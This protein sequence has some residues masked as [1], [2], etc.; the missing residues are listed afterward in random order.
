MSIGASSVRP[1]SQTASVRPRSKYL[2][3]SS[4][5]RRTSLHADDLH[6]VLAWADERAGAPGASGTPPPSGLDMERQ[7]ERRR[8][9]A[10]ELY[11][12]EKR[13]V[14]GL[15]ALDTLYYTPLLRALDRDAI[16][17]R[18][19]LNRL[20]A[21]F[22]DILQLSR[23]LLCRLEERVGDP[24]ALVAAAA[25]PAAPA[26]AAPEWDPWCDL[27]G[28]LL[29]PIAPFFKMYT[30]FMQNFAGAMQCLADERATNERFAAFLQRAEAD[31]AA[32]GGGAELGLQAQLLTLVQ[33]VPRYRLL[34]QQLLHHTPTW[35]ADHAPLRRTY[36][37]VDATAAAIN[38][39]VRQ[40]EL[41]LVALSL[42][43][44]LVG[45]DEPLVVPGRRLLRHG[46]LLKTRRKDIQP[47]HVYLFSDCLLVTSAAHVRA[48]RGADDETPWSLMAGGASLYL[49]HKLPL[50]ACTVVAYDEPVPMCAGLPQSRSM[51]DL[52]TGAGGAAVPLRHRF[53]VHSPQC[54]FSLYAASA[55]AKH[56]WITAIREAHAD[57]L[58]AMR[59]LRKTRD[60]AT[61]PRRA[62]SSSS[63]SSSG[64]SQLSELDAAPATPRA[65]SRPRTPVSDGAT[66]RA[67]PVLA[68]YHP[69]VWVPDSVA[70]Q[71]TRCAEPFTLWRRRHH[72]RLCGHVFCAT[73]SAGAV[74]VPSAAPGGRGARARACVAC[75]AYACRAA[76]ALEPPAAPDERD[77]APPTTPRVSTAT[78]PA[79]RL[80]L[81]PAPPD[82]PPCPLTTPPACA[83][84]VARRRPARRWS[85]VSVPRSAGAPDGAPPCHVHA[86]TAGTLTLEL[87][88]RAAPA[89]VA[90]PARRAMGPPLPPLPPSPP[91]PTPAPPSPPVRRARSAGAYVCGTPPPPS[92]AAPRSH[93]AQWLYTVLHRPSPSALRTP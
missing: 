82:D 50:A 18:G 80:V 33:R 60:A 12:S 44:A 73:C 34:L 40:Q 28:D 93:A 9:V 57:H 24:A 21:N 89:T 5:E 75:Y 8:R 36:E 2:L 30:L 48:E 49:T 37:L 19:T 87:H 70:A 25:A 47:R 65:A 66:P 51:P 54:S 92:P 53:D 81:G 58:A 42:Q 31:A 72:C 16:V 68:H 11:E 69:P 10:L 14:A 20:F 46:T 4:L 38:E 52:S 78:T 26:G 22:V 27:L 83:T 63:T 35:H 3:L 23:E 17:S 61:P 74:R 77:A 86:S 67:V 43:R 15:T 62:S 56:A 71:C 13:Y 55:D 79:V 41:T 85:I 88:E 64:L 84:P 32:C 6:R 1:R 45:L 76:P 59:S 29:V 91:S 39:H 7:M 90:A